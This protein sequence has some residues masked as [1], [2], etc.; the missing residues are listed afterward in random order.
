MTNDNIQVAELLN[1]CSDALNHVHH[2]LALSLLNEF[3]KTYGGKQLAPDIVYVR[4]WLGSELYFRIGKYKEGIDVIDKNLPAI[5]NNAKR[6]ISILIYKGKL[7][8]ML[9][10]HKISIS[11]FSEALGLAEATGDLRT[12]AEVYMEM[13]RM[14]ASSYFGL[15]IYFIRKAEVFWNRSRD[16]KHALF[17]RAERAFVSFMAYQ[18]NRN[19]SSYLYLRQEAVDIAN[20]IDWTDRKYDLFEKKRLRYIKSYIQGDLDDLRKQ[21]EEEEDT[22]ALPSI[23]NIIE[24]YIAACMEAG[25]S[26]AALAQFDKYLK[27]EIESQGEDTKEHILSLKPLLESGQ[28]IEYLPWRVEKDPADLPDLLDV[29]DK[30]SMDEEI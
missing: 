17:A 7:E 4:L 28:K 9:N 22:G 14:F 23:C 16:I 2:D 25:D 30:I 24:S 1:R 27:Y 15:A 11:S 5:R 8:M 12:I 6:T 19:N 20:E 29:L 10:C 13:S 26:A 3:D 18:D 21:I